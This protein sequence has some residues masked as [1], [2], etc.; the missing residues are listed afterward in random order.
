MFNRL[1][2]LACAFALTACNTVTDMVSAHI[3]SPHS[4]KAAIVV[5][6]GRQQATL[7]RGGHEVTTTRVSTGREGYSTPT[8]QFRVIRKD[9]D[10]RSSLYGDYVDA[11]GRVVRPNVDVRKTPRPR[12][13]RFVGAPMPFFLEF[14]PGYGLHAGHLPGYPASHGCIR[15]SYWK[16]RQF[17]HAARVGTRVTIRR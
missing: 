16:A 12:H 15:L 1:L 7:L 3:P 5:R 9:E 11:A 4:G 6:L 10:H 17:Y 8:G 14:K 13:A 2:P